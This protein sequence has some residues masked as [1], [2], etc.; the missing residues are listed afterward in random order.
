MI[1]IINKDRVQFYDILS[2]NKLQ[3]KIY[4]VK[5]KHIMHVC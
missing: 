4:S 2:E 5:A 3:T 1:N